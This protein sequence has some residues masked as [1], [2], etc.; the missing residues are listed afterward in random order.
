MGKH[1]VPPKITFPP[2]YEGSGESVYCIACI[3]CSQKLSTSELL[4]SSEGKSPILKN[5]QFESEAFPLSPEDESTALQT[6]QV[7]SLQA[8]ARRDHMGV[9]DARGEGVCVCLCPC[10]CP[11]VWSAVS[12]GP[13][14]AAASG[15]KTIVNC[16]NNRI[17]LVCVRQ[18][19]SPACSVG[20]HGDPS[21]SECLNVMC[22]ALVLC[23]CLKSVIL[24]SL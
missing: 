22:S 19:P 13:A 24:N 14:S 12:W 21:F 8:L 6:T 1:R 5:V 9:E 20:E 7:R 2:K 10:A 15:V 17:C 18:N 3:D 16:K 11:E 4:W 23:C